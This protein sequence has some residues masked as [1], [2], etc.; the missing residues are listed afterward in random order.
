MR[1]LLLVLDGMADISHAELGWCTPLQA[2]ST[3]CMDRLA[4]EGCSAL[5]YPLGPGICPSSEVAHWCM[6]G[7]SLDEFPGRAYLHAL[8]ADLPCSDGDA[9]FML[10]L[11]TVENRPQGLFVVEGAPLPPESLCSEWAERLSLLAPE[12]MDFYHMGGIEIMA[13]ITGGSRH[14]RT[15]EPF[16]RSQPVMALAPARGWEEDSRAAWTAEALADLISTVEKERGAETDGPWSQLGLTVKWPS[17]VTAVESFEKRVGMKAAAVVSTYCFQGMGA[18]LSMR[19]EAVSGGDAEEELTAKLRAARRLFDEGWEFVF[20]HTKWADE[21]AHEGK[22]AVKKE[23]IACM[24][25]A[26]AACDDLWEDD[27]LLSVITCDHSTPTT[28]D[29]RAIHGGDPV[30][31]LFHAVTVRR[32]GVERFDETSAAAGG[33]GQ[34]RGEDLMSMVLYL[35]R[36]APFYTGW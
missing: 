13:V 2:A 28:L 33:M 24:D 32:D 20:V 19:V 15:T 1:A 7:Y 31:L 5:M 6:F 27:E 14:L 3:P 9:L 11:V 16:I 17:L 10:N 34:L 23:V 30:P 4:R 36:R 18:L 35:T 29:P 25:R 26:M 22:P 12:G 21:A 8:A